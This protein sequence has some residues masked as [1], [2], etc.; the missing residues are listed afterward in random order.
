MQWYGEHEAAAVEDP[1]AGLFSV[2]VYADQFRL[3]VAAGNQQPTNK[4]QSVNTL[5]S[6]LHP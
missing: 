6:Y 2:A 5:S 1:E 4:R 3:H